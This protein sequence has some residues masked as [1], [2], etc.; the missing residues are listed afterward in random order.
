MLPFMACCYYL[1]LITICWYKIN[2]P[3]LHRFQN[4][5]FRIFTLYFHI[6]RN[7]GG[8]YIIYGK[9]LEGKSFALFVNF[10]SNHKSF[11]TNYGLLD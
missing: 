1:W 5:M 8:N 2:V 3:Y 7:I 10:N 11:P 9:T 6:A 4:L